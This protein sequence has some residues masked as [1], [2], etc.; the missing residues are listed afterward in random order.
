[1]SAQHTRPCKGCPFARDTAPGA[2]GGKSGPEVYIGQTEGGFWLPC[3]KN[4]DPNQPQEWTADKVK[5]FSQCAG[6]AIFRANVGVKLPAFALKLPEDKVK[7]FATYAEFLSHHHGGIDV[8]CAE[9]FLK[10][11]TPTML[12]HACLVQAGTKIFLVPKDGQ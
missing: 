12:K 10:H 3:H 9:E 1:M 5:D 2:L 6:A 11:I 8:E 4:Y 7:V